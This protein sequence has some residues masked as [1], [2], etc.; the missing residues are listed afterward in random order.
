MGKCGFI[1]VIGRTN[2]GKSSF[3]NSV[4][5][6]KISIVTNK[7]QTTRDK[8]LGI[9]NDQDS[10]LIFIDTPGVH[11]HKENNELSKFMNK[12]A[13]N[14]VRDVEC[15]LMLAP[16]NETIG[17]NDELIL[18]KVKNTKVPL[19][20]L[21]T[22]ADLVGK[23]EIEEKIA[24]WKTKFDKFNKIIPISIKSF[25]S[26]NFVIATIKQILPNLDY[27][28]FDKDAFT[29]KDEYFMAK[30]II[31]EQILLRTGQEIPHSSAIRIDSF[32]EEKN[33]IR[34]ATTIFCER[35]S[36]KPIIIGKGGAKLKEIATHSRQ[37]LEAFFGKKIF[38]EF[39]VK[40]SRDW[41]KIRNEVKLLGYIDKD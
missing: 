8:I 21:I 1:S 16:A 30:E 25:E 12:T 9:Y 32:K 20:L 14:S 10:Q 33:I 36:Q 15:I 6:K 37:E 7:A 3:V 35:E 39:F 40:V 24:E 27:N 23:K 19:I 13:L 4:I 11:S 5:G 2:V 22:K 34:I 28:F 38:I 31:R 26:I 41:R 17:T 18:E 29:D